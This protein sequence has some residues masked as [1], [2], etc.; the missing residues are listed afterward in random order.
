MDTIEDYEAE[1][2]SLSMHGD[3]SILT[4]QFWY[5]HLYATSRGPFSVDSELHKLLQA[6]Y[7]RIKQLERGK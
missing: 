3:M 7:Q 6:A 5:K 1:N 4:E 2:I